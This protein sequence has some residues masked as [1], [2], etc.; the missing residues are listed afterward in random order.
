METTRKES[1]EEPIQSPSI[2]ERK[3]EKKNMENFFKAN[4]LFF[5][6]YDLHSLLIKSQY[7]NFQITCT[8]NFKNIK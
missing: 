8:K 2:P 4:I 5:L 1:N 7:W 3:E 6:L